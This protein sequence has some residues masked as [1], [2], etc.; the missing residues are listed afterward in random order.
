MGLARENSDC[1]MYQSLGLTSRQG[2]GYSISTA[3][4]VLDG[5][6]RW[7]AYLPRDIELDKLLQVLFSDLST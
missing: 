1:R 6:G 7:A 3:I 5:R 2:Q 4:T